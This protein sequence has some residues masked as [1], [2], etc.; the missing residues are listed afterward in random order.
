MAFPF[1]V[2]GFSTLLIAAVILGLGIGTSLSLYPVLTAECFGVEHLGVNYGLMFSAYGL[3]AIAIQGG[4]WVHDL[5]GTYTAPLL[6]A[7]H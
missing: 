2:I 7:G 1:Y 5:T 3:G 4:G 6:L